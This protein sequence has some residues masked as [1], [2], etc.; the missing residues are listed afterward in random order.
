MPAYAPISGIISQYDE[1]DGWYLKFYK[2]ST[3][4]PISMA[5]DSTGGTLLAK[6]QLDID[7]FPTTD[8]TTLFIPFLNKNYDAYLFPT[9]AE[10]D[11]NNTVNAKRVAQ[12]INPFG[13]AF[14][15]DVTY[16]P[17]SISAS[18]VLL[19]V[20][21]MPSGLLLV[22][23]GDTQEQGV[24]GGDVKDF[25]YDP[26]NGNITLTV[27]LTGNE[28]VFVTYGAIV[29]VTAVTVTGKKQFNSMA[30][31]KLDVTLVSGD[32]FETS[33]YHSFNDGG[34]ATYK[35]VNASSPDFSQ[36]DFVPLTATGLYAQII[37]QKNSITLSQAGAKF[38]DEGSAG[39]DDT[40]LAEVLVYCANNGVN[41]HL[42]GKTSHYY[43]THQVKNIAASGTVGF[44]VSG[45]GNSTVLKSHGDIIIIEFL[46][47]ITY[48]NMVLKDFNISGDGT[49]SDTAIKI[50]NWFECC[51]M[52][53]IFA[54][55]VRYGFH[56]LQSFNP[57]FYNC[58]ARQAADRHAPLG[59][60]DLVPSYGWWIDGSE[61]A[62]NALY[63]VGCSAERFW[64]NRFIDNTADVGNFVSLEW[65]GGISQS[66]WQ[67][68]TMIKG[69]GAQC[70][71]FGGYNEN[72][73]VQAQRV[74]DGSGVLADQG[75]NFTIQGIA[76]ADEF[77]VYQAGVY[78]QV[79]QN[80]QNNAP[81]GKVMSVYGDGT[82]EE[83]N[84]A[85]ISSRHGYNDPSKVDFNFY[86]SDSIT[87]LNAS[88]DVV[89]SGKDSL[90]NVYVGNR[91]VKKSLFSLFGLDNATDLSTEP[92]SSFAASNAVVF[93][94]F[95][96][97]TT[98][99]FTTSPVYII[100]NQAGTTVGTI[101]LQNPS[102]PLNVTAGAE[103]I[104]RVNMAETGVF[105]FARS[106][107]AVG[108]NPDFNIEIFQKNTGFKT[109]VTYSEP[110]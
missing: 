1:Q 5:T 80:I 45:A 61:G 25:V 81:I 20:P 85:S 7:G 107:T 36:L 2:P 83:L 103:Y 70:S 108:A 34:A 66:A 43:A 13:D 98:E 10:A 84:F 104:A 6:C 35:V 63:F 26:A 79:S 17:F 42:D 57:S 101:T 100:Q 8:G 22:I 29:S 105:R 28:Q 48:K 46:D 71:F 110:I 44:V 9:A 88:I 69:G 67:T 31:A 68:G 89:N 4:T 76:G 53:N 41:L 59:G 37:P 38:L 94:S 92:L 106:V 64:N 99:T 87:T 30:I 23:D 95:R 19:N 51:T 72:N 74:A 12:N 16:L 40:A 62:I 52:Q 91:Y 97:K 58:Y 49:N 21:D 3:T 60:N 86:F 78:H 47:S 56:I 14:A 90:S 27:A 82:A 15:Q 18:Q 33:G 75:V 109:I 93:V 11:A 55:A 73:W 96:S 102:T 39:F 32:T 65:H 77:D 54:I 50:R 24:I